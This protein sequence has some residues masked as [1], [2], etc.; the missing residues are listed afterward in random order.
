MYRIIIVTTLALSVAAGQKPQPQWQN[1]AEYEM[2]AAAQKER[3][4]K[5]ILA[6]TDAWKQKYPD[7]QFT[8]TRLQLYLNAYQQLGDIPKLVATL[9]QVLALEP[10]DLSVMSPLMYYT[11]A[12][13]DTSPA[14]LDNA[15]KVAHAALENLEN[16]P[17]GT[18]DE[19]WPQ[20][21]KQIECLAYKTLGWVAMHRKN[22]PEA[23]QAFLKSLQIDANQGEVDLWM[24]NA[25]REE[26]TPAKT[27][28]ALFYYARA[29]TYAG[30]GSLAG[31]LR[32][33][34]EQYLQKAY[35]GYH[36]EDEAGLNELKILA[37]ARAFPPEGFT[38]QSAQ[39]VA[40]QKEKEF[41]EK[42]PQLTLWMSVKKELTGSEGAQYFETQ[43]KDRAMPALK[44]TLI[45]AKPALHAKELV[46]G[47]ADAKVPEVTLRL[48]AP[49]TGKPE[50]GREI[51][52]EGI[53]RQFTPDPF[54]VTMEVERA[55]IKGLVV[56]GARPVVKKRRT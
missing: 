14:T 2:Y 21:R 25:L 38:I 39:Q 9:D 40:A 11:L 33:Q 55:K 34:L 26:K 18:T 46:I 36:G 37:R 43:M 3:D 29:A 45:S 28:A 54:Q 5:K 27:S 31:P 17:A 50:T 16:K 1:Q 13:N 47:I 6:L 24:G 35:K 41:A 20:A 19:Q 44:G 49:L 32:Q 4:P 22:G 51:E 30:N 48:D 8:L 10:K 42:N 15:F 56:T 52:F 53:A 23:E 7:T 12:S